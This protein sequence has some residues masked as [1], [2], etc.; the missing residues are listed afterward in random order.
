MATLGKAVVQNSGMPAY[1]LIIVEHPVAGLEEKAVKARITANILDQ[2]IKGLTSQSKE[3]PQVAKKA[4]EKIVYEGEDLIDAMRAMN[5]DFIARYWGDG[6]PLV[7]STPKNVQS[8]LRATKRSPTDVIGV[9]GPRKGAVTVKNIATNAV[10]AG[11]KPEY[12]PVLIAMMEAACKPEFDLYRQCVTTNPIAPMVIISGPITEPSQLDINSGVGVFG[13]GWQANATIGRTLRLIMLSTGGAVPGEVNKSTHGQFAR[14]TAAWAVN[15]KDNPFPSL[16]EQIFSTTRRAEQISQWYKKAELPPPEFQPI[17]P[18]ENAVILFPLEDRNDVN[19]NINKTGAGILNSVAAAML[20]QEL[21]DPDISYGVISGPMLV[22]VGP[23][24]AKIISAEGWTIE[25][26]RQFLF[27][28]ARYEMGR[29]TPW[30]QGLESQIKGRIQR[31]AAEPL[32]NKGMVTM[33]EHPDDVYFTVT[34]GPGSHSAVF[35]GAY[36][37]LVMQKITN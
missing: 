6:L 36:A 1:P 17:G 5:E 30:H 37:P 26:M 34:G 29:F 28:K 12:M 31:K 27:E 13:P 19:D 22:A 4:P 35:V 16:Q 24:H 7:P 18:D 9:I 21:P 20:T 25:K 8:M 23:Q 3:L 10:M 32:G 33:V 11:C 15:R 14:Y 2:V